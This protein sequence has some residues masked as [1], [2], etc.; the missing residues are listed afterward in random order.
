MMVGKEE[1]PW[2]A[3]HFYLVPSCDQREHVNERNALIITQGGVLSICE[4]TVSLSLLYIHLPYVLLH[5]HC[6]VLAMFLVWR[7]NFLIE[8]ET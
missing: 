8:V 7:L 3:P 1:I 2:K 5:K 6:H 4:F